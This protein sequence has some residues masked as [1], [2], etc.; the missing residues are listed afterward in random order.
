MVK[1]MATRFL[2]LISAGYLMFM[3]ILPSLMLASPHELIYSAVNMET[4]MSGS[5]ILQCRD[6]FAEPLNINQAQIKFWL[7]RTSICDLDLVARGDV[8]VVRVD[9]YRIKLNITRNLEG[10]Y[11]CGR[12]VVQDAEIVV[13]ESDP[14]ALVCKFPRS[15]IYTRW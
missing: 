1:V 14:V 13:E 11:T 2:P 4:E 15:C 6:E 12:L 5:I 7:N 10:D 9:D 8:R 3:M